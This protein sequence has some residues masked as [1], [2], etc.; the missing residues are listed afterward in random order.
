[1]RELVFALLAAFLLAGC[2]VQ[3]LAIRTTSGI[4]SYGI[5]AI[6]AEP[7]LPTAEIAVASNLKLLEGFYR[8]DPGNETLQLFLTQG[9]AAYS[10]A[11]LET[12]AP[13][14]AS[15]FY[16]RARDYGFEM[17]ENTTGAFKKGIPDKEAD[18]VARLAEVKKDDLPALFW[19]AFAWGGWVNLNR[20]NPQAV[21]DL[22]KVKAM[23]NRCLELD[24]TYFF[25]A[26][27]LFFGSINGSIPRMLGGDPEKAGEQF[28]RVIEINDGAFLLAHVYKARYYAATTLNE[29]LFD[30]LLAT[31][32]AAPMDILPDYELLTALAKQRARE[33]KA[34]KDELL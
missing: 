14:R 16:L 34:Q 8:A 30:E 18:F 27:Y 28:D 10:L 25:G 24:D 23:M 29:A 9:F 15:L 7:D 21:F 22:N 2:S 17:L 31:V 5:E 12:D 32:E 20:D 33:L 3:K 4:F 1:M 11:F 13:D 6:Y 26:A 19:T